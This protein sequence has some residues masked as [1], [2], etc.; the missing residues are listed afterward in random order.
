MNT[1]I[2][3]NSIYYLFV[4]LSID[5]KITNSQLLQCKQELEGFSCSC[6]KKKKK[7]RR[8]Q[9]T[10]KQPRMSEAAYLLA[11]TPFLR[12]YCLITVCI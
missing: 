12:C 9:T 1:E 8:K 7:Q 4:Y 6:L 5:V 3:Y 11:Y 2:V 10:M